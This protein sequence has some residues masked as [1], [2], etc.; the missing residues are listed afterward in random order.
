MS[1]S[2]N[3]VNLIG[4]V[5]RDP[6]IRTTQNGRR[7]ASFSMAM[8][9]SWTDKSGQRQ[10]RTEWATIVVWTEG[11][12]DVVEK[13]V[14]KGSRLMARGKFQTRKWQDS[15]GSSRYTTEV[16]LSGYGGR[17]ILLD[18]PKTDTAQQEA[19]AAAG[20]QG[21][22]GPAAPGQ[23]GGQVDLDDEIP[24]SPCR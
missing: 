12:V 8:N 3:E 11:L 7:V 21:P 2:L 20:Y 13:Y 18:P 16:V 19:A 15:A 23:G 22:A 6:E 17:L 1:G 9:E 4:N 14:H 24:F 5:G 10:E